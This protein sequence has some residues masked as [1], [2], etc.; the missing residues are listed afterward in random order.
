MHPDLYHMEYRQ[1]EAEVVRDAERRRRVIERA[2]QIARAMATLGPAAPPPPRRAPAV[3]FVT[4]WTH[5]RSFAR[6][7]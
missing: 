5:R 1:Q 4:R 6:P 2:E 3:G 7:A